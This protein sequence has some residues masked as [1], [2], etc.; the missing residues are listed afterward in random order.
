MKLISIKIRQIFSIIF[1]MVAFFSQTANAE[2]GRPQVSTN[3]D[4]YVNRQLKVYQLSELKSV[5][6]MPIID[7]FQTGKVVIFSPPFC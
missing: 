3:K 1:I 7:I 5:P 4:V 2:T 6:P